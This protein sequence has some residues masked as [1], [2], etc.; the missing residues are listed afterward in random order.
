[1]EDDELNSL[2]QSMVW[3]GIWSEYRIY[4]YESVE[5]PL[6]VHEE[7]DKMYMAGMHGTASEVIEML[8]IFGVDVFDRAEEYDAP[9]VPHMVREDD[10][11]DAD[12]RIESYTFKG[13]ETWD[14]RQIYRGVAPTL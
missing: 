3:S 2:C 6:S 5:G 11:I 13:L 12:P 8:D 10:T 4:E 9:M 1:M 14:W 7:K